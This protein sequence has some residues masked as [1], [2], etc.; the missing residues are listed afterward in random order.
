MRQV[1]QTSVLS[2]KLPD[3]DPPHSRRAKP[4]AA[5]CP[6]EVHSGADQIDIHFRLAGT[7]TDIPIS[8][9]R[10]IARTLL[11]QLTAS[12]AEGSDPPIGH[13]Q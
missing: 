3:C 6:D 5:K 2:N 12:L 10:E 13:L 9:T 11:G 7:K 8:I 4:Q 1:W